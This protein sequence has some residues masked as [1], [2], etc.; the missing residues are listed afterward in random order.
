MDA[1]VIMRKN[2]FSLE[3]ALCHLSSQMNSF[4][5]LESPDLR[6]LVGHN[7]IM[8]GIYP[9]NLGG[10]GHDQ[11]HVALMISTAQLLS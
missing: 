3:E 8:R 1:V 4:S 9:C 6:I 10:M 2:I 11:G 7:T 5:T